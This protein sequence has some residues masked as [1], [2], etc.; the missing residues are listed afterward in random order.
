MS[1]QS[2]TLCK[3]MQIKENLL[4]INFM[5]AI[6]VINAM[7]HSKPFRY[8]NL[9][10][11]IFL[12]T[13]NVFCSFKEQNK[14]SHFSALHFCLIIVVLFPSFSSKPILFC[15]FRGECQYNSIFIWRIFRELPEI[16]QTASS[17]CSKKLSAWIFSV[18][19]NEKKNAWV[20]NLFWK[21]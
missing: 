5:Q 1:F 6:T 19:I 4:F 21:L 7:L 10:R 13:S 9:G 15:S 8:H 11:Q 12:F 2:Y 18:N 16:L 20:V 17:G 3:W 14:S